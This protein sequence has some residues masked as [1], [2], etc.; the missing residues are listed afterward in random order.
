[1]ESKYFPYAWL[2]TG[3]VTWQA[4]L[5]KQEL[6]TL[7]SPRLL[8]WSNFSFLCSI[9]SIIVCSSSFWLYCLFFFLLI[10]L[11]VL[12]S[13]DCIVCSSSTYSLWLFPWYLQT[14]TSSNKNYLYVVAMLNYHN[15]MYEPCLNVISMFASSHALCLLSFMADS[16][17]LSIHRFT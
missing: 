4:P 8:C 3:F 11:S 9:L 12:L 16:W 2:M 13:F 5:V 6:F 1:M 14:F 17:V 7:S 10:V 15:K